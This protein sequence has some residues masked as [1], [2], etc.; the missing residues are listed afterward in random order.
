[1][2]L[3]NFPAKLSHQDAAYCKL[4]PFKYCLWILCCLRKVLHFLLWLKNV[5]H[6]GTWKPFQ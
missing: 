3:E 1:M 6:M 5:C 4:R 2:E